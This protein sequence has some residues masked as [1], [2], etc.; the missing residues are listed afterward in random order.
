MSN[1]PYFSLSEDT[2]KYQATRDLT[3]GQIIRFAK[4]LVKKRM[5]RGMQ[6]GSPTSVAIHLA[7]DYS[8]LHHEVF[9]CLFLDNKHRLIKSEEMFRGSINT[10]TIH[11]RE[12]VKRSLEL[13]AAAV[14]LAHNHPSGDPEPSRVDILMTE[15]LSSAL[16]LIDV[17]VLDHIVIGAGETVSLAEKDLI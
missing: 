1:I 4:H 13:N 8:E 12:V 3:E 9:I 16:A 6:I 14:V 5:K 11:P 17:R 2:G 7:L 10:A 15:Q